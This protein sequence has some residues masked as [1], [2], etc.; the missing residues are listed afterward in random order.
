MCMRIG[1]NP[2]IILVTFSRSLNLMSFGSTSTKAYW[3][4]VSWERKS[5]YNF[6]HIT[7]VN[8][9][10]DLVVFMHIAGTS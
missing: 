1:C 7:M 6:T 10:V 8:V 5:S 2:Q 3:H 9:Y 4:Q